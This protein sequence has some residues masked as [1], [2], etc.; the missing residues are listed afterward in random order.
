MGDVGG[1]AWEE[2]N[3]VTKG[4]NYGWPLAEGP[5]D[6][7]GFPNPIYAYEHVGLTKAGSITSVMVYTG[8]ALGDSYKGKVF[9]ADYTVKWMKELTFDSDFDSFIGE[10]MFDENAGTTVRLAQGPDGKI[11]QSTFYPG[12]LSVIGPTSGNRT[13]TAVITATPNYGYAPFDRRLLL[14]RLE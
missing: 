13:P 10:Q 7:C 4:A 11:Y 2:L 12:E 14:G 9:I 3:I 8:D 6:S 5:C 1:A